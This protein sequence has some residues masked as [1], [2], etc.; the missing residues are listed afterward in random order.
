MK[1]IIKDIL[2][3][4]L[5]GAG[6]ISKHQ[7][8]FII[9]HSTTTNLL[10]STYDWT[11]SLNNRNPVD[12]P[13]IDFSKAIDSVVHSK[14][15]FNLRQISLLDLLI[16]WITAFLSDRFQQIRIENVESH[17]LR[18]TSGVPQGS[19]LGPILVKLFINDLDHVLSDKASF[20]LFA[21][22][23]KIC[24][25]FNITS[26]QNN[27]QHA[28]DLLML[29][30]ESWQL[31]VNLT[32][33]QLL[34]L[35]MSINIHTYVIND[36]SIPP[37]DKVLDLGIITDNDLNHSS[38]ISSIIFKARSR[39]GIIFEV[40]SRTIFLFSGKLTSCFFVL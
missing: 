19:V 36:T 33:T 8:A 12:I 17:I 20:K 39:T 25:T 4:S 28:L 13:Y 40:F 9:K 27:H 11:V 23:L 15:I 34:H 1:S 3:S 5:L 37:A 14:L 38:H 18:V 24:S 35:G 10:E 26:S 22:D 21:D 6:R 16:S 32:K 29:W 2:C 7:H 30:S 31:P